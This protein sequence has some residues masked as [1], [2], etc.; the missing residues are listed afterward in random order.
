MD[1]CGYPADVTTFEQN[2]R[3]VCQCRTEATH[4]CRSASTAVVVNLYQV[5]GA[6]DEVQ[7]THY[8]VG[9]MAWHS[10]WE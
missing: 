9:E 7:G 5:Y 6:D 1:V 10:K 4:I 8:R 2:E 3:N